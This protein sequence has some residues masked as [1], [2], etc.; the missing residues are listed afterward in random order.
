MLK[1]F[2]ICINRKGINKLRKRFLN[3]LEIYLKSTSE[4][5]LK[6]EYATHKILSI[7]GL[8]IEQRPF[9]NN[10]HRFRPNMS[11][12]NIVNVNFNELED[13]RKEYSLNKAD[14]NKRRN[15]IIKPLQ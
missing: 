1:P 3:S 12:D 9:K 2:F 14:R 11:L 15:E 8:R 4:Y 7:C 10:M 6:N 13:L 5:K